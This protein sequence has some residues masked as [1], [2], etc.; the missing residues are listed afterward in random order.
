MDVQWGD[1]TRHWT[2]WVARGV[3]RT[4]PVHPGPPVLRGLGDRGAD[5]GRGRGREGRGGPLA[6]N[7]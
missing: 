2:T 6:K 1:H 3:L 5:H 7:G 4:L